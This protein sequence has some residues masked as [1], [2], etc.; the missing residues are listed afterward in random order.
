MLSLL[1]IFTEFD[2]SSWLPPHI[3]YS[4]GEGPWGL[5]PGIDVASK[6]IWSQDNSLSVWCRH[7]LHR[8][9]K[10]IKYNYVK[11]IKVLL[12]Y[13]HNTVFPPTVSI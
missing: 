6:W 4:N 1:T 12:L 7:R 11:T 3:V 5:R 9:G 2:D 13:Y 10:L 8:Q